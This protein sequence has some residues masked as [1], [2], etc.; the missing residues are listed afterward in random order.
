MTVNAPFRAAPRRHWGWPITLIALVC[1]AVL[2]AATPALHRKVVFYPTTNF[3]QLPTGNSAA[4][5]H[6]SCVSLRR[7]TRGPELSEQTCGSPASALRVIARVTRTA[8]C[9]GDA[10]LSIT[11]AEGS[12]SSALCMDYDWSPGQCLRITDNDVAKV[13]CARPGAIQPDIAIIGA[14]DVSYCRESGIAHPIRHFTVCTIT[15]DKDCP[16]NRH[17]S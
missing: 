6:R 13:N 9:V 1:V 10:D 8:D 4:N 7:G 3:S 2:Y 11:Q 15:G 12:G 14:V 5:P 16:R 17:D